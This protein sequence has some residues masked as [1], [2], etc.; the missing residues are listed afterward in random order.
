[1]LVILEEPLAG[2][3]QLT[4]DRNSHIYKHL[5]SSELCR[6]LC[7]EDSFTILD[8][9]ATKSQIRLEDHVY[10]LGEACFESTV[11]SC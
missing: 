2:F 1:M 3:R 7:S 10:L 4:S 5:Q 6:L 9:A 11:A 8:T